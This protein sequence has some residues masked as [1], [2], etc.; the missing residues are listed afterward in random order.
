[1]RDARA[2]PHLG[3]L[4]GQVELALAQVRDRR[5]RSA[6]TA[7][8]SL[9]VLALLACVATMLPSRHDAGL[10][11]SNPGVAWTATAVPSSRGPEG[12]TLRATGPRFATAP[13]TPPAAPPPL[14]GV[15]LSYSAT[16]SR[17][18]A[19]TPSP[20]PTPRPTYR[21][22]RPSH[23]DSAN[24]AANPTGS[25]P[26]PG[27]SCLA[28]RWC[29]SQTYRET[30]DGLVFGNLVCPPSR[31]GGGLTFRDDREMDLTLTTADGDD[32]LWRWSDGQA[33]PA[34]KHGIYVSQGACLLWQIPWDGILD[35]GAPLP[36]GR[37]TMVM[38]MY[39][40]V[41]VPAGSATFEIR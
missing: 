20:S 18:S 17:R 37:Y 19:A 16:V 14:S 2:F 30:D 11:P 24:S 8:S 38:R 12:E 7:A 35:S 21:P 27:E 39:A 25:E 36:Q 26:W 31:G 41:A 33:F 32:V 13:A 9:T 34:H 40:D 4:P 3:P 6:W 28:A 15:A 10:V 29:A 22:R 23:Y 1:M 5:R